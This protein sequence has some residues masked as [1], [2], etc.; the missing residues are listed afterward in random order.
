MPHSSSLSLNFLASK[1]QAAA[2]V[3]QAL[4][5]EQ[6]AQYLQE[7]PVRILAP[8]LDEMETW[9]AARILDLL[10]LEQNAAIFVQLAYRSMASLLRLQHAQRRAALLEVLPAKLSRPLAQSLAYQENTVGAWMDMATPHFYADLSAQDCLALLRKISQPF[11]STL[12]VISNNHRVLG[13]VT[14]DALLISPGTHTLGELMDVQLTPLAAELSLDVARNLPDW[15]AYSNLPVRSVNGTFLGTLSRTAL[16]MALDSNKVDVSPTLDDSV[17]V[18]LVRAMATTVTGMLRLSSSANTPSYDAWQSA[19]AE[20]SRD[21]AV[22]KER[23]VQEV[24]DGQ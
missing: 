17:L 2:Q 12:T 7:I 4:D 16:H 6:A 22:H 13:V 1:P 18:H 24:S 21:Q 19:A 9:P 3:L 23:D 14:L 8:V 11:G 15:H 5:V 20:I 10:T